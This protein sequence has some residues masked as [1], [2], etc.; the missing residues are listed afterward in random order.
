MR[1]NISGENI[2]AENSVLKHAKRE[3]KRWNMMDGWG[4][5]SYVTCFSNC[6]QS[7]GN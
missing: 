4:K 5:G 6:L 1:G 2:T 7:P 3:Y